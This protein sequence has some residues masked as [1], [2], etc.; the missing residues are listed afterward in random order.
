[1][2][3]S[4]AN[5]EQCDFSCSSIHHASLLRLAAT[6]KTLDEFSLEVESLL[7]QSGIRVK[8]SFHKQNDSLLL[9]DHFPN[10]S[11]N[12]SGANTAAEIMG[13]LHL[14]R[15]RHITNAVRISTHGEICK[16]IQINNDSLLLIPAPSSAFG[17][18]WISLRFIDT[19]ES[20][21][22]S[23][24]FIESLQWALFLQIERESHNQ[25]CSS[26]SEMI[27]F[28]PLSYDN[29]DL[30]K[31]QNQIVILVRDEMA[32]SDIGGILHI[33]TSLVK[34][35]LVK[36]FKILGISNRKELFD[37]PRIP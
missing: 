5:G 24:E 18:S 17:L 8:C 23:E 7:S 10:Y 35:E 15:M 6:A 26:C 37:P 20:L 33:S 32:N 29:S 31:R 30:T 4:T 12:S 9:E 11:S 2:K 28:K 25:I 27:P 13:D 1:M 21:H 36:I 16:C 22:L 19:P 14:A 34:M 3:Q